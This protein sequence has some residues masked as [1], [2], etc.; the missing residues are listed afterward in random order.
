M[1]MYRSD[2]VGVLVAV[3]A[4]AQPA[5]AQQSNRWVVPK[6]DI[7][8]GHF[9]VNSGL[10]YLR[11]ATE[12]KF[13]DQKQKDLTA[14]R[15]ALMQ[16]LTTG[17]QEKNPAAWYYLGRYFIMAQDLTGADTAFQRAEGLKAECAEDIRLW[18]RLV[19]VPLLNAGIAGWQA[20][21]TD[22]AIASFR[23]AN[24]ILQTEPMG[25]KYLASLLY[26]TGQLDSAAFYF[27]R[28]ADIAATDTAYRQDRRDALYN[29]ARIR[30]GQ[31]R[32]TDAETL[33]REYL[34]VVPNDPEVLASLG[35][36]LNQMGHRDSA[37]A[38]YRRVIAQGDTV[39]A[40]ALFRVGVEIFQGVSEE[41]DTVAA[42]RT[43]RGAR[44]A[45]ARIRACRDSMAHVMKEYEA[46]ATVTYRLASQAFAAGLNANPYYR[47]GL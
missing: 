30:H 3:L 47:D 32:W 17:S 21:N 27:R 16:A 12:T 34:G 20:N 8:P 13:E 37:Y 40:M 25:F 41:P 39:G 11:N 23:R 24:A 26:N 19:W 22:S 6:C 35:S 15:T 2:V 10:L 14:A 36:V 28:T 43:C 4:L 42:G 1:R 45:P 44:A 31:K 46:A 18:R 7:K 38:L 33:Y 5:G 29:L 9:L